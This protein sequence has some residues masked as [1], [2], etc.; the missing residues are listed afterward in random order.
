MGDNM[1]IAHRGLVKKGI[2]E[3]T[4]EAFKLAIESD[5][6]I[7]FELDIYTSLDNEFIVF[8]NPLLDNKFI[9]NYT[10]KELK[11]KKV[12]LLKDVLKLKTDKIILIDIKDI[13]IDI[14]K[15]TKLLNIYKDKNIYVMSFFNSVLK[16]FKNPNFKIGLLNYILNS[17]S[18]YSYDFIGILYDVANKHMIDTLNKM[19]IEVFLYALNKKDKFIYKDVYYIVDDVLY[20]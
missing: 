5:K 15:L 6:Y 3:N 16:K 9:W 19:N 11:K 18:T 8:H 2:T 14:K 13:K 1:F 7:G 4:L 12:I 17:T 20:K 10:S